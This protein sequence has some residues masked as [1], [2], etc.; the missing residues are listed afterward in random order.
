MLIY[1]QTFP[2]LCTVF[3]DVYC[4]NFLFMADTTAVI[5]NSVFFLFQSHFGNDSD[6]DGSHLQLHSTLGIIFV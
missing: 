5:P 6:F 4:N 1:Y 2:F 3:R